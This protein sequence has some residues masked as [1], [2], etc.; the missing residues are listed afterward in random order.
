[1]I[2]WQPPAQAG[3]E[4][5]MGKFINYLNEKY[6]LQ[7]SSFRELHRFSVEKSEEFWLSFCEFAPFVFHNFPRRAIV[8]HE[9][10]WQ[11]RFFPEAQ[12]NFTENVLRLGHEED[13]AQK[14]A[15][16]CY[17]EEKKTKELSFGELRHNSLILASFLQKHGFTPGKRVAA[18]LPNSWEAATALFATTALGG[19]FSSASPEF[20]A[21]ALIDR[22]GQINCEV[23]F[24]CDGYYYKGKEHFISSKVFELLKEL[25]CVKVAILCPIIGDDSL[26][27]QLRKKYPQIFFAEIDEILQNE[28]G[29]SSF[30]YISFEE[31]LYIMFSSGTTG[32]PKAIVQGLGVLVNQIKEHILHNDL[33]SNDT[34]LYYTTTGW[35][36]WNWTMSTLFCGTTLVLYDGHPFYPSP[37]SLW[38]ILEKEK[39]TVFGTSARYLELL[40]QVSYENPPKGVKENIRLLLST[41]SPLYKESFIYVH[42]KLLPHSQICSISGGTD[43]NGCFVLGNPLEPV[44]AG[45]IQGPA[46]GMAVAVY[47]EAGKPTKNVGELVCEKP[48]PAQPLYFLDDADYQKY[49]AS[50]FEKFPNVWCHGDFI[51]E[52]EHGG[53]VIYGRSDATLNPGGVRMG[54]A[55]FYRC[56]EK[57]PFVA[58]SL[59]VGLPIE[60]NEAVVL[61][62]VAKTEEDKE[63]MKQTIKQ[64]IRQKLSPRHVPQAIFFVP[65]IPYT[66]NG[67]KSELAVKHVLLGKKVTNRAA[68][69]KPEVLDFF[70]E[71]K[72]FF[73]SEL[74]NLA[75]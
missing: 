71:K 13:M 30:A 74:K 16:V 63:N 49:R 28:I 19:V 40:E 65:D 2:V 5:Q 72:D 24:F 68:L 58:D 48:F 10:F 9:N 8:T 27:A 12:M 15:L 34:L 45:E 11:A 67:K 59:V 69:A 70:I 64:E 4:T 6:S 75:R 38:E 31:P 73:I 23:L 43:L 54:T 57:L 56:L 18:V 33:R 36:M 21:E 35:M 25:S 50:Y 32:R 51:Q 39:V 26:L 20:G 44:Y 14:I 47:D 66:M 61:F 60:K 1:M 17:L 55:E 41:G 22:F 53:Y 46:L 52:T 42:E 29:L 3:K 37:A 7:L 62:V